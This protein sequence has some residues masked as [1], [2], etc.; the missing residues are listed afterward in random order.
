MSEAPFGLNEREREVLRLLTQGHDVKSAATS[1][2]LSV[3]TINERLREARAKTQSSSS[4]G[5]ARLLAE[6]EA[7]KNFVPTKT[8]VPFVPAAPKGSRPSH[9]GATKSSRFPS[10]WRSLTMLTAFIA[11]GAIAGIHLGTPNNPGAIRPEM[12]QCA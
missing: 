12:I 11:A 1:F 4:R 9:D 2:G 10:R 8:G 5:A 7:S 6:I 3:H